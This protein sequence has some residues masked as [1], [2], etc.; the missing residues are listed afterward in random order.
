MMS[1]GHFKRS[2]AASRRPRPF[3][4]GQGHRGRGQMAAAAQAGPPAWGAA[5]PRTATTGRAG[6]PPAFE[7]APALPI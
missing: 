3:D 2:L 5:A 6:L 7:T 4:Q 1:L